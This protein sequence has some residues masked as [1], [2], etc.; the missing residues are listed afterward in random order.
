MRLDC[1]E[2]KARSMDVGRLP[3]PS[4]TTRPLSTGIDHRVNLRHVGKS[5]IDP[6]SSP[7]VDTPHG[8]FSSARKPVTASYEKSLDSL[9]HIDSP[10]MPRAT[11]R[12]NSCSPPEKNYPVAKGSGSLEELHGNVAER[13]RAASLP[14]FSASPPPVENSGLQLPQSKLRSHSDLHLNRISRQD[15]PVSPQR[16][17]S[18]GPK[19]SVRPKPAILPRP[20]VPHKPPSLSNLK[21]HSGYS[22]PVRS[23]SSSRD[24][25]PEPSKARASSS[26]DPTPEP[27]KAR[28]S[29][30]RDPTPEPSKP[31]ASS[32]KEWT[33]EPLEELSGSKIGPQ[34]V[35]IRDRGGKSEGTVTTATESSEEERIASPDTPVSANVG[36]KPPSIELS[37]PETGASRSR[38][39]NNV[40]SGFV[41]EAPEDLVRE[42]SVDSVASTEEKVSM[43]VK[44]V[45]VWDDE[46]LEKARKKRLNIAQELLDTEK[47]YVSRLKLIA[48]NFYQAVQDFNA[49]SKHVMPHSDV[50]LMFL[51]IRQIHQLNENIL[52]ELQTR[53]DNWSKQ[54]GLGDVFCRLAPFLKLYSTYTAG[55]E[56]AMKLLTEWTSKEKRFDAL[57]RDFARETSSGLGVSHYMLEPVQR[58]PRYRLLLADYLKYLPEDSP[59]RPATTKALGIISEAADR[60]NDRIKEL[61]R[62]YASCISVCV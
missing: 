51:N 36:R 55:F 19:P 54:E 8:N 45:E 41:S 30:S 3:K 23:A 11:S 33:P 15:K 40:D 59:D 60:T 14:R 18:D 16:K 5:E 61:V 37:V 1:R 28:A 39:R 34:P 27:S 53:M 32:T 42:V 48:V 58:I 29:S 7:V 43:P 26:R 9:V 20:P 12:D 38:G 62:V 35:L 10:F 52:Q 24:P 13:E 49:R 2:E 57:V 44:E 17:L 6:G 22:R 46:K 4:P 21:D 47:T 25:T 56:D 50:Q 31:R